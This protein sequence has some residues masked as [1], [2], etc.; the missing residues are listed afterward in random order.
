VVAVADM[1]GQFV[2]Q[3]CLLSMTTLT[4]AAS[5]LRV[6]CL[7]GKGNTGESFRTMIKPLMDSYETGPYKNH[8]EWITPDAPYPVEGYGGYAWWNLPPGKR[9]FDTLEY[10]G[11]EES[12]SKIEQL[13]PI[14]AII[15]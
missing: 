11:A 2:T 3:F 14:D 7:H 9:S 5:S 6:L 1:V 10:L 13:Y 15:G 4:S 8:I 12:I